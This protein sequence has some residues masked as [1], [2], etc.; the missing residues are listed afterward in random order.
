M[1]LHA[2]HFAITKQKIQGIVA[3]DGV[4]KLIPLM[5]DGV[6]AHRAP[7]YTREKHEGTDANQKSKN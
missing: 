6:V 7:R 1:T 4:G 2:R 5:R 3:T